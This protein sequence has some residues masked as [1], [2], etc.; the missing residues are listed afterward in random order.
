[1]SRRR[2]GISKRY[3]RWSRRR[4]LKGI[5]GVAVAL[6]FLETLA[7]KKV[8][9]APP[10]R[11]IYSVYMRQGNGVQQAYGW[12]D[13]PERFWP[14]T[15]GPVTQALLTGAES[16]KAVAELADYADR[17][18]L[19]KGCNHPFGGG[20]CGHSSGGAQCLTAAKNTAGTAASTLSYGISV[21]TAVA[22]AVQPGTE[23]LT[24][25]SGKSSGYVPEVLSYRAPLDRRAAETNPYNVYLDF[26]AGSA[27]PDIVNALATQ[28]NRVNDLV[29]TEMNML[30][31]LDLSGADRTRL[32]LHFDAIQ[33]MEAE[34][35]CQGLPSA[36]I[37]ELEEVQFDPMA[38]DRL[39]QVGRLHARLIALAFACDIR[40]VATLQI[41]HGNDSTKFVIDGVLQNTFHRISHRI[42][43]DG[44]EGPPIPNA[45]VLH[46]EIDRIHG[47]LFKFLLDRL[48]EQTT[49]AGANLLD[50]SV[51]LWTN[52]LATGP[53]HSGNNLPHVIA[54]SGGGFLKQGVY[55]DAGDVTNNK[56]LSTLI[57]AAGV[58]NPDG[59]YV[60]DFG[61][62]ELEPGVV[63]EMIA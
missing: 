59:S 15:L 28:R 45:D 9:A 3:D 48:N 56:F 8:W 61:D 5:G 24:L 52:D 42:D 12:S 19:V 14:D 49:I 35:A 46:H 17:L 58:R 29:R 53:P 21:D 50:D 55:V 63:P 32:Q 7:D 31:D 44:S 43:G 23:P 39:E 6:P 1:M 26:F 27:N 36:V 51:A 11:P 40:R 2:N 10:N 38:N 54:G 13:E 25:M 30:L 22:N 18:L 4:F 16:G 41:G 62:P 60:D 47:R 37:A 57:N 34:M 33:D 20:D